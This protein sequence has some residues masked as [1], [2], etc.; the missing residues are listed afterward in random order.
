[1]NHS[2]DF[3]LF[4]V[5]L[6][7]QLVQRETDYLGA[8]NQE[9]D[10][11]L[12]IHQTSRALK[13]SAPALSQTLLGGFDPNQGNAFEDLSTHFSRDFMANRN[14]ETQALAIVAENHVQGEV[15]T[16]TARNRLS[17]GLSAQRR[18]VAALPTFRPRSS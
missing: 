18:T 3:H 6:G 13:A 1:M 16:P 17:T 15:E 10:R 11:V 7:G 9:N 4:P 14:R 12:Q 8:R 5:Q 2:S